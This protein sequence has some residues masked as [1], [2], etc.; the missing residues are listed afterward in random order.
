MLHGHAFSFAPLSAGSH[1]ALGLW[2]GGGGELEQHVGKFRVAGGDGGVQRRPAGPVR[3]VNL[4]AQAAQGRG[5][6]VCQ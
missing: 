4:Q 3:R 6:P 2:E 5:S 1:T